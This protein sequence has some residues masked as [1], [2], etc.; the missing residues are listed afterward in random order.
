MLK[1][2]HLSC[3][4]KKILFIA[5]ILS[6]PFLQHCQHSQNIFNKFKHFAIS[7]SPVKV[8]HLE[9]EAFVI[10]NKQPQALAIKQKI[11]LNQIIRTSKNASLLLEIKNNGSLELQGN[12]RMVLSES[13]NKT[14][15]VDLKGGNLWFANH[16]KKSSTPFLLKTP[17]FEIQ[18]QKARFYTFTY[19]SLSGICV[20]D[21]E[22]LFK[23]KNSEDNK[24]YSLKK[25]QRIYVRDNKRI[26]LNQFDLEYLRLLSHQHSTFEKKS[27]KN[28]KNSIGASSAFSG[29]VEEAESEEHLEIIKA[30]VE[31]RFKENKL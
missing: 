25:S 17:F 8:S 3:F 11:P 22:I 19:D 20:C 24:T 5:V 7:N 28:L 15:V 30:F 18:A 2:S 6:L 23:Q 31:R 14:F 16:Q 12:G 21:G 9:N 13:K 29:H 26:A 10:K 27:Q 4:F 1:K